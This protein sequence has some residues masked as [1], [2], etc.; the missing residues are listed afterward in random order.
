M[1]IAI[2]AGGTKEKIDGV[3]SITNS[4]SGKLGRKI[5]MRYLSEIPNCKIFYIHGASAEPI[6]DYRV[7]NVK[8][9][10]VA[11]LEDAVSHVLI[12]NKVDIFVHSMAVSDYTTDKIVDFE[13]LRELIED[14]KSFD[15]AFE[16]ATI[17]NSTKVSSTMKVPA[18]IM[19]QTPK[20]IGQIKKMSPYTFLIGFK[21]LD[22]VPE[23][24]LFDV[25]FNLLRKNRCNMVLANDIH[26]IRVGNHRG[27]VIY[28]EK[29]FDIVEG[30]DAIADFLVTES[31]KRYKVKHPRSVQVSEDNDIPSDIAKEFKKTGK[32][33]EENDYLPSVI[34]Y[35]RD[36]KK[37]TY[38][39]MSCS[40]DGKIY[41]T[42]RNVDKGALSKKDI[43]RIDE[44]VPV[45]EDSVYTEVHYNGRIKPSI[46]T[47]I[48]AELYKVS[49]YSHIIHI[50]TDRVFLGYP[51]V[52][53]SYP[54]G[55]DLECNSI[56]DVVKSNPEI[57][58]V[59]MNKHGIIVLGN[60]LEE[61][62]NKISNLFANVPSIDY[63]SNKIHEDCSAHVG[64]VSANFAKEN[65]VF[66]LKLGE[67]D[68]GCLYEKS[69]GDYVHFGI[70]TMSVIRGRGLHIVKKYLDLHKGKK[71]MLHTTTGCDIGEFYKNKYGFV[72]YDLS[73]INNQKY[74]K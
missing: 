44:V 47:S 18:I 5:A 45:N 70:Y 54:C 38:G 60:S 34:N 19:K 64:E 65:E 53:V 31:L 71:F 62:R 24:E 22:T 15:K 41:I 42:G 57:D 33:L 49:K 67:L 37:G 29:S 68:I 69:D 56:V 30:K 13:K 48:H 58:I 26:H 59:Q 20:I 12:A 3:R 46:D 7:E 16:K 43:C 50:H 52:D 61:C 35:G 4:S 1:I 25:G 74:V 14:G 21:L 36:D 66:P 23:E 55:C 17:D 40:V 11:D 27:M 6:I 72:E 39:N 2:T 51:L 63:S 28:P 9:T 8:I 73:D 10:S 32:W